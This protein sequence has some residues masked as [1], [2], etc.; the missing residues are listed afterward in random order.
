VKKQR[1]SPI[2]SIQFHTPCFQHK[3]ATF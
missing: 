3:N 2:T 1:R